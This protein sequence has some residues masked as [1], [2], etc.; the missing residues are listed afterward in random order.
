M[1]SC[2]FFSGTF[3]LSFALYRTWRLLVVVSVIQPF[4]RYL[5]FNSA[6]EFT[7]IYIYTRNY[8][9][10]FSFIHL[11]IYLFI[12]SFTHLHSSFLLPLS[13]SS[14]LSCAARPPTG[15]PR[16]PCIRLDHPVPWRRFSSLSHDLSR[17][18]L[19]LIIPTRR[20][21]GRGLRGRCRGRGREK[22]DEGERG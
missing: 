4:Y 14:S 8:Y 16:A 3:A 22:E 7:A 20:L 15:F 19:D 13:S 9:Y 17:P 21:E 12:H 2:L 6:S 10:F 11:L 18:C 1:F 5:Y